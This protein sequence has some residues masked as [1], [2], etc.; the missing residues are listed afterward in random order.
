MKFGSF[1]HKTSKE[2]A[3]TRFV[4]LFQSGNTIGRLI[5]TYL[6]RRIDILPFL[7]IGGFNICYLFNITSNFTCKLSHTYNVIP[8]G[9]IVPQF[10]HPPAGK[11]VYWLA[12]LLLLSAVNALVLPKLWLWIYLYSFSCFRKI[13]HST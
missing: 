13:L 7:P 4:L 5:K 10:N 3:Y 2:E 6:Y 9:I 12:L 8:V 11:K 1:F